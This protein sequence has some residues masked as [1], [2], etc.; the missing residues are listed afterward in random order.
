MTSRMLN[1]SVQHLTDFLSLSLL[2]AYY[3]EKSETYST[4]N[5]LLI[6]LPI[7]MQCG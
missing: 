2:H 1:S 6:L 4:L 3:Y 5:K 7:I